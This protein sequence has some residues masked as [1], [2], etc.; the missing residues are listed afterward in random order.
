MK[1]GVLSATGT[2]YTFDET[3]D[4]YGRADRLSALYLTKYSKAVADGDLIRSLIRGS[5][6]N[7]FIS[8]LLA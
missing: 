7:R 1:A 3:A 6:V 4:G 8:V 2:C 5:A